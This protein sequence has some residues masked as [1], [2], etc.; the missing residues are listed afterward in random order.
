M[1]IAYEKIQKTLDDFTKKNG[2][3]PSKIVISKKYAE[4][5]FDPVPV[6]LLGMDV[7]VREPADMEDGHTFY[8]KGY[9]KF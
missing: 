9:K 2:Y 6:T 8:L 5:N 3:E 7:E 4:N 1:K